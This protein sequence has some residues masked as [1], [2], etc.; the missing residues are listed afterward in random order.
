MPSPNPPVPFH[1]AQQLAAMGMEQDNW[2]QLVWWYGNDWQIAC[3]TSAVGWHPS[4]WLA[5]PDTVSAILWVLESEAGRVLWAG[6]SLIVHPDG[7]AEI[8]A[9]YLGPWGIY[10]DTPADLLTAMLEAVKDA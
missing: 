5:A 7:S 3:W 2:P 1:Q 4:R 8:G 6:N 9:A 10:G